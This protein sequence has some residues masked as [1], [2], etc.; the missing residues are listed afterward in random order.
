MSIERIMLIKAVVYG[1]VKEV[2]TILENL[3]YSGKIV[4]FLAI[5]GKTQGEIFDLINKILH[6]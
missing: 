3:E 2:A 5:S 1:N 4:V 6:I